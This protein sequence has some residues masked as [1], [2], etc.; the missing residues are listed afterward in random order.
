LKT[1]FS[2]IDS[3][4][5]PPGLYVSVSE[6]NVSVENKFGKTLELKAGQ[7]GY[8]D[9][10]GRQAKQLTKVPVFQR[11]DAYPTPDVPNPSVIN[12]NTSNLG[13]KE[14]GMVCEIK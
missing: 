2:K 12:L 1:L 6:G 11:F 9:V 3:E 14:S 10:L 7:S 4:D 5:A 8:A 13:A